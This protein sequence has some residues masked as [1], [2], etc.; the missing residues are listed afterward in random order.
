[1]QISCNVV[2]GGEGV[3][4]VEEMLK[5]EVALLEPFNIH[6]VG[7]IETTRDFLYIR[8]SQVVEGNFFDFL[9]ARRARRQLI[10]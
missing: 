7:G 6:P 10:L 2:S 3:E 9:H 4:R 8:A 5:E 1:M